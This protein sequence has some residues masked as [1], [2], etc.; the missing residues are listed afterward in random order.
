MQVALTKEENLIR[1]FVEG[2]TWKRIQ[3]LFTGEVV[4]VQ[5]IVFYFEDGYIFYDRD[6]E[7]ADDRLSF[8]KQYIS[9]HELTERLRTLKLDSPCELKIGNSEFYIRRHFTD[10]YEISF[11]EENKATQFLESL[12]ENFSSEELV[13]LREALM[14]GSSLATGGFASEFLSIK[15]MDK[16]IRLRFDRWHKE[17]ADAYEKANP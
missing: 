1:L 10:A 5:L 4:N 13:L 3:Q 17:V 7:P 8:C 6:S 11:A 14:A 9:F 12:R 15:S 16:F 2:L